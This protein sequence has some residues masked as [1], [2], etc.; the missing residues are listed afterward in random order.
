MAC[1]I[2]RNIMLHLSLAKFTH[3]EREDF[4]AQQTAL[5]D[6]ILELQQ[7]SLIAKHFGRWALAGST[8]NTPL[9]RPLHR[10]QLW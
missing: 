2:I 5:G 1:I 9:S 10:W 3:S 8:D 4:C 7:E 6:G